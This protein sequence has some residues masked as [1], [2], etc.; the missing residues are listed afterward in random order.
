VVITFCLHLQWMRNCKKIYSTFGLVNQDDSPDPYYK[1]LW[2]PCIGIWNKKTTLIK[3]NNNEKDFIQVKETIQASHQ[4]WNIKKITIFFQSGKS[5]FGL[6][7][8]LGSPDRMSY[9]F[10]YNFAFACIVS[11]T[12]IKSFS[13]LLILI[14]VVFLFHIPMQ[15]CQS[16]L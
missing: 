15:G 3:I 16:F 7:N 2:H 13:L 8:H 5:W 11:F 9:K 10:F 1:K 4:Q 12:C 6:V 14:K